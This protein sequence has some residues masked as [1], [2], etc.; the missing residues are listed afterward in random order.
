L[1]RNLRLGI[2][3]AVVGGAFVLLG[4]FLLTRIVAQFLAP[5]APTPVAQPLTRQVVVASHDLPI[6]AYLR[7]EDLTT[8]SFPLETIP[9]EAMSE[10]DAVVGRMTKTNMVS[11]EMVMNHHLVDPN[12]V[13]HDLAY[14]LDDSMVLMAFPALD[15]MSRLSIIQRGDTID[16]LVSLE[17]EIPVSEYQLAEETALVQE[18]PETIT[19]LLTFSAFQKVSITAMVVDIITQQ[20]S[21]GATGAQQAAA[22]PGPS[23]INVKAYLL[24]LSP[25]DAL[26]LKH[27]LDSGAI[28]DFVLRSPTSTEIFNTTP[29]VPEY[30]IDRYE[31]ELK[32]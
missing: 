25:Q 29:V 28:F 15:L 14:Q 6:G 8:L 5:P 17:Q 13:N 26:V 10:I 23:D 7:H 19:R 11:G 2:L 22:T 31:L 9:R 16:V 27:L 18:E 24:A 32:R 30:L 12:A 4:G 3:I 20:G 1:N 21:T